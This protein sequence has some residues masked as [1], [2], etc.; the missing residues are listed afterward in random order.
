MRLD[1][2]INNFVYNCVK[3]KHLDV[4]QPE[5]KRNFIHI[6]DVCRA[7]I[8]CINNPKNMKYK[9]Y[10]LGDD[11]LNTTKAAISKKIA[12][13]TDAS[14]NLDFQGKDPDKR[15]YNCTSQRFYN[16]GYK[17]SINF[18]DAIKELI[19]YCNNITDI[20]NMRIGYFG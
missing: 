11:K 2:L 20:S 6:N 19:D 7:F 3:N 4:F 14:L 8:H 9:V 17:I 1:L 15:S 10:N 13:L 16:T 12:D 18:E 5:F